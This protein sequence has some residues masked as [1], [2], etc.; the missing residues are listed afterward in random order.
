MALTS[1]LSRPRWLA[2][3]LLTPHAGRI[4]VRASAASSG[5][6]A[7]ISSARWSPI[8]FDYHTRCN[9]GIA[10]AFRGAVLSLGGAIRRPPLRATAPAG[11]RRAQHV[12]HLE[13]GEA[14]L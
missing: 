11:E 4:P 1:C 9:A 3:A 8:R 13:D 14:I 6:P 2:R 7:R 5:L 10:C 12:G